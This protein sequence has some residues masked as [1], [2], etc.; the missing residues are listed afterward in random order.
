MKYYSDKKEIIDTYLTMMWDEKKLVE[1]GERDP[2]NDDDYS[3]IGHYLNM[4]NARATS[5]ACGIAVSSDG[6]K[7]WLN[8]NFH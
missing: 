2:D 7:G 6:S 3:Y 4:K 5:V 8:V 1:S